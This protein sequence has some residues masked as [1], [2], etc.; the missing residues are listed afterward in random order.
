MPR[1]PDPTPAR[2]RLLSADEVA[3]RLEMTGRTV[4]RIPPASLPYLVIQDR[5]H[6]RY[7]PADVD[8][9]LRRI[10]RHG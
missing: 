9:F 7:D 8:A 4:R 2:G 5:G 6:R 3:A 10:R 1:H